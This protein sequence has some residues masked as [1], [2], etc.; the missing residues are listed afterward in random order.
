MSPVC[1]RRPKPSKANA[2]SRPL[3]AR[4][5]VSGARS[6]IPAPAA[7][8]LRPFHW[9]PGRYRSGILAPKPPGP[10]RGRQTLLRGDCGPAHPFPGPARPIPVPATARLRPFH[11]FSGRYRCGIL[12]PKPAGPNR[13]RQTLPHGDCGPGHPFPGPARPIPAPV[14]ARLRPFH[15][16]PGRYRSVTTCHAITRLD[17]LA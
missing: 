15:W 4:T 16:F 1:S 7:A 2:P 10:N 9:F 8:R 17:Q 11:W 14:T 12:A 3:R 6:P 5:P 13:G